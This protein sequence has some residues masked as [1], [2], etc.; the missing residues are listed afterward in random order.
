MPF[1][2]GG[3][4]GFSTK[5]HT[6]D[7]KTDFTLI[8]RDTSSLVTHLLTESK[9]LSEHTRDIG[10]PHGELPYHDDLIK[11]H[12]LI[13]KNVST[14]SVILKSNHHPQQLEL[15][16]EDFPHL[17]IWSL[18]DAPFICLEPWFSHVDPAV[19]DGQ[20]LTKPEMIHLPPGEEHQSSYSITIRRPIT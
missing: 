5:W 16:F 10:T 18:P 8:F 17:G 2:I 11:D 7:Q 15:T 13:L 14:K 9:L 4:P 6:D 1:A 19:H 12:A 3:H 20:L